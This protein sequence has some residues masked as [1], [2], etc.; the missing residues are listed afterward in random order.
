MAAKWREACAREGGS[1]RHPSRSI[2]R[3]VKREDQALEA[4]N[5]RIQA[6]KKKG[7]GKGTA[8]QSSPSVSQ[9][10]YVV[11]QPLAP[12]QKIDTPQ[13][14]RQKSSSPIPAELDN[15]DGWLAFWESVKA[16]VRSSRPEC[17][18]AGLDRAMAALDADFWTLSMLFKATDVQLEKVVP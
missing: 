16:A 1:V 4:Q 12:S 15:G 13:P 17:C 11:S 3:L 5:D 10:F 14:P 18:Q 6:E 2:R 9:V 8:P 7:K